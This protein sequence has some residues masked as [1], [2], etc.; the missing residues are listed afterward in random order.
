M[1]CRIVLSIWKDDLQIMAINRNLIQ[2]NFD[3]R[4]PNF[5]MSFWLDTQRKNACIKSRTCLYNPLQFF[6]V[7]DNYTN[8][9]V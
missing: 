2:L 4:P 5:T 7:L 1:L 8:M 6:P 3:S 9:L